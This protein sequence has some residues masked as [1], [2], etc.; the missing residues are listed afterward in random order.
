MLRKKDIDLILTTMLH[1]HDGVSDLNLTV[2]RP[3]QVTTEGQLRRVR[4]KPPIDSLT[5][6]QTAVLA[7]GV[8][9]GSRVALDHLLSMGAAD[10]AYEVPDTCR[11][12]ANV[13]RQQGQMG[14]VLR[15]LQSHI[16][17][18]DELGFPPVFRQIV[19][20]R[21]GLVLIS[22]SAGSGRSTTLAALVNEVL[23][24]RPVHVVTLEDPVEFKHDHAAA[25][26]N[27]RELG[28]D[29]DS[30][31][32]GLRAAIRQAPAVIVVGELRD[33]ETAELCLAAATSGHLVISTLHA[34][35]SAQAV[36]RFVSLFE[37][38][39]EQAVRARLSDCLTWSVNQRLIPAASGGRVASLE[40]MG[41]NLR[42]RELVAQ[43]EN[44]NRSFYDAITS[45][46]NGWQ[47]HDECLANLF[48]ASLVGAEPALA[49]A[50]RRAV[51]AR[52]VDRIKQAR[53]VTHVGS[54][55]EEQQAAQ[56]DD[57]LE[58]FWPP[59][60]TRFPIVFE[61]DL[62]SLALLEPR[63]LTPVDTGGN[64]YRFEMPAQFTEQMAERRGAAARDSRGQV[65]VQAEA[66]LSSPLAVKFRDLR[67][68][69]V[70]LDGR[71]RTP[72]LKQP[73]ERGMPFEIEMLTEQGQAFSPEK[74]KALERIGEVGS[75]GDVRR[76]RT[77]KANATDERERLGFDRAIAQIEAR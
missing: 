51:L 9:E 26:I 64:G 77:L 33:R 18:L 49:N 16:R 29:F 22:G 40:I 21:E 15:R 52:E 53:G 69:H 67:V 74:A 8:L 47:T 43:G 17:S 30:F 37:H 7:L 55:G 75:R 50:S 56:V 36:A 14:L 12:R 2:G 31:P 58:R 70:T 13:F 46:E 25:T 68:I 35:D 27:Q 45:H 39:E 1:S 20:Q 3:L 11:F 71:D 44:E 72:N 60:L 41:M 76:L 32:N 65:G 19:S 59:F 23:H 6:Y 4:C 61:T 57:L 73:V 28:T 42:V 62:G 34:S 54:G 38:S 66:D 24:Y 10:V 48:E 63:N 5:P